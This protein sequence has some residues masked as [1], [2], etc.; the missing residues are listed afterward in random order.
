MS[1]AQT[2][3]EYLAGLPPERRAAV[4]GVRK[5]IKKN[6]PRGYEEG[7]GYGMIGY[8]IPLSRYPDTYNK[9]PLVVTA[10]ASQK[11]YL[12]LHLTPVY[13]SEGLRAWFET[14]WKKSGKRLDMGK[15]CVRWKSL[16]DLALDV[17]GE[18]VARVPVDEYIAM[19]QAARAGAKRRP[20]SK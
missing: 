10:I 18:V 16:D 17:V 8:T 11:S 5:V 20:K 7:I 3:A 15:G 12:S 19:Y 14:A 4:E 9:Q 1:K 2:V 6:L 13:M